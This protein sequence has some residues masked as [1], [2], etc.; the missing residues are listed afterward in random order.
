MMAVA[1]RAGRKARR[2]GARTWLGQTIAGE[3]L[4]RAKLRQEAL[5]LRLVAERV[6]HPGR[7]VVYRDISGGRGAALRQFLEDDR[8][9]EPG[10]VRAADIA[11]DINA[12]E[13]ERGGFTQGAYRKRLILVPVRR[14]RHHR[15]AGELR[16]GGLKGALVLGEGE[17]H[18]STDRFGR[19]RRQLWRPV[20]VSGP[21]G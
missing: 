3:M 18:A 10:E 12:A 1:P 13:A 17:I 15:I 6:D 4:H 16:R 14:T 19:G 8:G 21:N 2:I 11:F 9:I 7:H 20:A 5:A